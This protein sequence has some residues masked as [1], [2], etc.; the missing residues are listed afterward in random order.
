MPPHP[1][2]K[3]TKLRLARE[4]RL[5]LKASLVNHF[6]KC[7]PYA[8]VTE[9]CVA[10]G[11]PADLVVLDASSLPGAILYQVDQLVV[12]KAGQF[13]AGKGSNAVNAVL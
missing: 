12:V 2:S 7:R 13:I 4:W 9:L 5:R 3:L 10:P 11:H 6:G 8:T 1:V